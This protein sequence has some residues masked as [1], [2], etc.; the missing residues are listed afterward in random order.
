MI[1]VLIVRLAYETKLA[2]GR[3]KG[4]HPGKWLLHKYKKYLS[5][6]KFNRICCKTVCQC[7]AHILAKTLKHTKPPVPDIKLCCTWSLSKIRI[8]IDFWIVQ[9]TAKLSR[10]KGSRSSNGW[11]K[12]NAVFKGIEVSVCS[13]KGGKLLLSWW[14]SLG[15]FFKQWKWKNQWARIHVTYLLCTRYKVQFIFR[16]RSLKLG[17]SEQTQPHT[18]SMYTA[19]LCTKCMYLVYSLFLLCLQ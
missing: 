16:G 11:N 8:N 15:F 3:C 5:R 1:L 19:I 4:R 14:H 7:V 9:L 18:T 6:L 10:N 12:G 13:C 17:P 2:G